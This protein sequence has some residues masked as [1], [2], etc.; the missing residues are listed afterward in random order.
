MVI[1]I[2]LILVSL[3]FYLYLT[4]NFN[5]WRKRGVKG[6]VPQAYLGT[7]PKTAK[8]DKNSNYIEETTEIYR[9]EVVLTKTKT[10][11]IKKL[12]TLIPIENTTE[13]IAS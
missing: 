9:Y 3:V 8:L 12:K 4:W 1:V 2:S 13:N 6:P 7:F 5:Y 10:K 11:E